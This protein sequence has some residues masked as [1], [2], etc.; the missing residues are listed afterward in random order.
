MELQKVTLNI[1]KGDREVLEKWFPTTGWSVAAR[2]V[3][4]KF[5]NRLRTDEQGKEELDIQTLLDE[6][7]GNEKKVKV[8]GRQKRTTG[9]NNKT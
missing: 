8:K 9:R 3:I 7:A 6:D 5:C 1:I 2:T 4:H